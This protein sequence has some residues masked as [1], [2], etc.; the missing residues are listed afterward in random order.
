[1]TYDEFRRQLGKASITSKEFAE[2]LKMKQSSITNYAKKQV[3]PN[4]LAIIAFLMAEM[5]E[6]KVDF[7]YK[8]KLLD[9]NEAVKRPN[10]FGK[11]KK[12][13]E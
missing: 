6:S 4:H 1:M 9:L 13:E 7:K 12:K 10:A 2:L 8:L 5:V 3:V 11:K